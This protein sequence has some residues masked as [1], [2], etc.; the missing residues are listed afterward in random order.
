MSPDD[1]RLTAFLLGELGADESQ[2]IA[3]AIAESPELQAAAQELKDLIG[4]LD[5]SA[6]LGATDD[7]RLSEQQHESILSAA[8][9]GNTP[10][11]S[12]S[13]GAVSSG[14]TVLSQNPNGVAKMRWLRLATAACILLAVGGTALFLYRPNETSKI[15]GA[16]GEMLSK[17]SSERSQKLE[18][19]ALGSRAQREVGPQISAIL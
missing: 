6:P 16:F 5:D 12:V 11:S 17:D 9:T 19:N 1:P 13:T 3:A 18:P 7:A 10:L 8:Q 2:V 4:K 14:A 15:A